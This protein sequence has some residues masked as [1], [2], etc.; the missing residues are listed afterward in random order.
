MKL[1]ITGQ[2]LR[3]RLSRSDVDRFMDV[4]KIEETIYFGGDDQANFSYALLHRPSANPLAITYQERKIAV[5]VAT[6]IAEQ[7]ASEGVGMQGS[8]ET[9]H[10]ALD[11]LI[12][13]DFACQH[14]N[15]RDNEDAFPNPLETDSAVT[16]SSRLS[17]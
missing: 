7:W 16:E 8:V 2:S 11:L 12:E 5:I 9:S 14:G 1:R 6:D 15:D 13:K 4:G 3:F 10:G 17:Q